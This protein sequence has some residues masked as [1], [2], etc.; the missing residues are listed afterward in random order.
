MPAARL[1]T[2]LYVA[3]LNGVI[4][5]RQDEITVLQA[6]VIELGRENALLK[7]AVTIQQSRLQEGDAASKEQASQAEAVIAELQVRFSSLFC[8]RASMLLWRTLNSGYE[9]K[10][11]LVQIVNFNQ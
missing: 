1:T 11:L 6:R 7:R 5:A 3:D 4:Q 2:C 8:K 10:K 9:G